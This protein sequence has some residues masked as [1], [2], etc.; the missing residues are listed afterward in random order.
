[1]SSIKVR[2]NPRLLAW[3]RTSAGFSIPEAAGKIGVK[4]EKIYAWES[5]EDKP[6]VAQL[7]KAAQVYKR[8]LSIFFLSEIPRDFT[9]PHDFRR[10][11]GEVA[12]VYSPG[13]RLELRQATE[14]REIA[15]ALYEE[16]GEEPKPFPLNTGISENPELVASRIRETLGVTYDDQSKWRDSYT[17]FRQWKTRLEE[18]DVLVFQI[19]GLSSSEFRGFSL[20]ETLVPVIAVNRGETPNARIFSLLH[21]TCHLMLRQSGICDFEEDGSRPELDE[22]TEVFCNRIAA[23]NSCSRPI[24]LK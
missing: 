20:A 23:E 10:L 18:L 19:S 22:R 5:G 17:A 14:R 3:A 8:P 11:P 16:L 6:T 1:M 9:I 13:L 24:S 7:R 15:L 2:V 4:D 21:E 12:Y